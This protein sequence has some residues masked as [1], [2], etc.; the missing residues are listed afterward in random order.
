MPPIKILAYFVAEP[1]PWEE[2]RHRDGFVRLVNDINDLDG[3]LR[4]ILREVPGYLWFL[5]NRGGMIEAFLEV[6]STDD[7]QKIETLINERKLTAGRVNIVQTTLSHYRMTVPD[8]GLPIHVTS[9][10]ERI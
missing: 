7:I 3:Q 10:S 4:R 1:S 8:A 9:D 2:S 5:G 6:A